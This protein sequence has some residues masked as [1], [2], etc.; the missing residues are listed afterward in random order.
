[1]KRALF[2]FALLLAGCATAQPL[3]AGETFRF[4]LSVRGTAGERTVVLDASADFGSALGQSIA[5]DDVTTT[6][7]NLNAIR[8][9]RIGGLRP[10]QGKRAAPTT[11]HFEFREMAAR[12]IELVFEYKGHQDVYRVS[13][14]ARGVNV[15]PATGEFT[16]VFTRS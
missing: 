12:P 11:G 14:L 3:P 10:G 7:D 2:F 15:T 13:M 1:M 5:L 16:R 9:I 6:D 4:D 8:R